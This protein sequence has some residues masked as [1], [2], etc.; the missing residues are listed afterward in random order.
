MHLISFEA[1]AIVAARFKTFFSVHKYIQMGCSKPCSFEDSCLCIALD[2]CLTEI[3]GIADFH[4]GSSEGNSNFPLTSVR[5]GCSQNI[6]C[7]ACWIIIQ[8][9]AR[10]A[11]LDGHFIMEVC[12]GFVS[13]SWDTVILCNIQLTYR[14]EGFNPPSIFF[15][16]NLHFFLLLF[17]FNSVPLVKDMFPTKEMALISHY[18]QNDNS[19]SST[20]SPPS[21]LYHC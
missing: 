7:A 12:F 4:P 15:I 10:L 6:L 1:H 13:F 3:S 2:H 21:D 18:G 8:K 16:F 14:G 19:D 17:L 9:D 5:P 20:H 11:Q